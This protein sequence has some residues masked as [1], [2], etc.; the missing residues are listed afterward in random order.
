MAEKT[1]IRIAQ[2]KN[3]DLILVEGQ[4][5][6]RVPAAGVAQ[7]IG[8]ARTHLRVGEVRVIAA[9]L[10]ARPGLAFG[11][12]ETC[13]EMFDRDRRGYSAQDLSALN[14]SPVELLSPCP[15]CGIAHYGVACIP[16]GYHDDETGDRWR[17][18]PD[19][20]DGG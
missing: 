16:P 12:V 3:D 11:R 7:L 1:G 10:L 14:G 20:E 6:V 9:E 2:A 17:G 5:R 8:V 4:R 13:G 19:G 18:Q 15:N